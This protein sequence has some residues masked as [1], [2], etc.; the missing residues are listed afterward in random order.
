MD[1]FIRSDHPSSA[2]VLG[3]VR[4][5]NGIAYGSGVTIPVSGTGDKSRLGRVWKEGAKLNHLRARRRRIDLDDIPAR[6][7]PVIL[8]LAKGTNYIILKERYDSEKGDEYLVQFPDSRESLVR[9]NRIRE[10]YDGTC[11]FL[12][13]CHFHFPSDTTG[14]SGLL[15]RLIMRI[16]PPRMKKGIITSLAVNGF[17][18]AAILALVV[19]HRAI[20]GAFEERPSLLLPGLGVLLAGAVTL[21]IFRIRRD[22]L[23]DRFPSAL[24]DCCFI[25]SF[26]VLAAALLGWSALSFLLVAALVTMIL[27][28]SRRLGQV[29]SRFAVSRPLFL[30][31]AFAVV[32]L[33]SWCLVVA[34]LLNHALL[35]GAIVTGT[36]LVNFFLESDILWQ[37]LR[38]ASIA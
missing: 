28:L 25:P 11:V 35:A 19:S 36:C 31:L 15:R 14:G 5:H 33:G 21:G 9:G 18:L 30:S 34:G 12:R 13:A 29:P 4:L 17:T 2:K 26:G 22:L 16:S 23:S 24:V 37:E 20:L 27:F 8:E 6:A 3:L 1:S 10:I 38:L 7:F 32:A